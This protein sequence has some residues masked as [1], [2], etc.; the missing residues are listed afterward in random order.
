L[1]LS[2]TEYYVSPSGNNASAGT[3]TATAW[4]TIQFALNMANDGDVIN[5]MAGT[6]TGKVTWNDGGSVRQLH[7]PAKL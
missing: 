7:H 4:K 5:L 3:S 6:Y 2:A 1:Q